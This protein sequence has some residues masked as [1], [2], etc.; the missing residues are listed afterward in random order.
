MSTGPNPNTIRHARIVVPA[1]DAELAA[2]RL[3]LAGA[4]AVEERMLGDAVELWTVLGDDDVV[5]RQRIGDLPPGWEL[6]FVD[7]SDEPLDTWKRYATPTL[8]GDRLVVVPQWWTGD[9][10]SGR[11]P[12][13]IDPG[14]AFGLG[15]HPTTRLTLELLEDAVD[16]GD[17]VLDVG[18]GTGVLA[19][20]ALLMGAR[21]AVAIDV[22]SA[23]VESTRANAERNDV[24]VSASTAALGEVSGTFEVVCA[25]ILAPILVDLASGLV[26]ALAPDGRLIISGVRSDHY[27]H[28]TAALAPLVVERIVEMNGWVAVELGAA[29]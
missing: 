15:D 29:R 24:V 1:S 17:R 26:D 12:I 23:A 9:V 20:A 25:N 14:A 11:I 5:N 6:D 3:W 18:C 16:D 7:T 10:P 8:V 2:D 19:I 27:Q 13:V 28:V 22:S 21:S 4:Q